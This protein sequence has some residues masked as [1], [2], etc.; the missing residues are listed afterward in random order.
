MTGGDRWAPRALAVLLASV[1]AC[2]GA[3]REEVLPLVERGL[4]GGRLLAERGAG[5]WASAQA[6]N[7]LV[8]A[9]ADDR[10]LEVVDELSARA[11][12]PGP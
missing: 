10:A 1:A 7:A 8:L 12:T 11:R 3:P 6:L 5:G 2:R 4:R 9:E